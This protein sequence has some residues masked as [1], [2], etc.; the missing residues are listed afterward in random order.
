ME[1]LCPAMGTEG[2]GSCRHSDYFLR[3][4]PLCQVFLVRHPWGWQEEAKCY[5]W[6]PQP[7][8]PRA[9]LP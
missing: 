8:A 4:K 3:A 2:R 7:C 6:P 5:R 1:Q 9:R